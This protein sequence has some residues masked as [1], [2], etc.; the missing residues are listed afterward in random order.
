M[1]EFE[2]KL[3]V[4]EL[5]GVAKDTVL[6]EGLSFSLPVGGIHGILGP[7]GSG[8]TELC[9][10]LAGIDNF[11]G[12][13]SM[14]ERK[15]SSDAESQKEWKKKVGYVP[16]NPILDP[17]MT[18]EEILELVGRL[19][20]VSVAKRARQSAE[21]LKLTG[22]SALGRRLCVNLTASEKKKLSLAM[23]LLGN[24]DLLL[25][26]EPVAGLEAYERRDVEEIL[27]MLGER[28]TVL[29]FSSDY[30]T[31]AS[32]SDTVVLLAFGEILG[33]DTL[34]GFAERLAGETVFETL[35]DLYASLDDVIEG[36]EDDL[37]DE[38]EET[39]DEK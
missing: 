19:R 4:E 38:E 10:I 18:V 20:G 29:V 9:R 32:L 8:K 12:R 22:L 25:L 34:D 3:L 30:D 35:R 31:V 33:V 27:R 2:T 15:L 5:T 1:I 6:I 21:A 37:G 24:P 7:H 13:I 26:D 14:G 11:G 36:D 28:K 23:S 16:Q 39:E 17:D